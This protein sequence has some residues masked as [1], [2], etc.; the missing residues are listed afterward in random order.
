MW[1]S[2]IHAL[3]PSVT[4]VMLSASFGDAAKHGAWVGSAHRRRGGGGASTRPLPG[5]IGEEAPPRVAATGALLPATPPRRVSLVTTPARAVPLTYMVLVT[6]GVGRGVPSSEATVVPTGAATCSRP[7]YAAA[8]APAKRRRALVA[9]QSD[10]VRVV[11]HL[12]ARRGTPAVVLVSRSA[13]DG[14]L[15]GLLA[16]PE[17]G[18]HG[19]GGDSDGAGGGDGSNS[20]G[21]GGGA[22]ST[23]APTGQ[24]RPPLSTRSSRW[25]C[26]F[27]GPPP[28]IAPLPDCRHRPQAGGRRT[29]RA[30]AH[31]QGAG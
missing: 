21:D 8:V 15:A 11:A 9:A 14:A 5:A 23:S 19:G 13:V 10:N 30:P 6:H 22:R 27:S 7:A 4:L 26:G 29:P 17:A 1:E 28:G 20:D 16:A 24:P 3:P 25:I 31:R 12:V 2:V 18:P